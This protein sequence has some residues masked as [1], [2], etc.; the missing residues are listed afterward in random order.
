MFVVFACFGLFVHAGKPLGAVP[1]L[2]CAVIVISALLGDLTA[3]FFSEPINRWLRNA[4]GDGADKLGSVVE[5]ES[6]RA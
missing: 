6:S 4:R 2:F 3:R 1:V 5:T